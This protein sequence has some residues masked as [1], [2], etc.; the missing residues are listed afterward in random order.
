PQ[1]IVYNKIDLLPDNKRPA[2]I[3]RDTQGRAV[4]VNI[5][6]TESLGLDALREAMIER[7]REE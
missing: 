5:S 4:A 3:L 2:G 1:L 6:V 7:A